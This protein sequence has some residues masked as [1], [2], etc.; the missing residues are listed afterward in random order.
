MTS[1][2]PALITDLEKLDGPCREM[3][4]AVGAYWPDPK[5]F[6]MSIKQQRGMQPP[7][8]PFTASIDAAVALAE[9]VLPGWS[10]GQ[11]KCDDGDWQ[12]WLWPTVETGADFWEPD[13]QLGHSCYRD[14]PSRVLGEHS[15][16]AIAIVIATLRASASKEDG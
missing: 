7:V 3:D 16:E 4:L 5:P 6:S 2:D 1:P 9:R 12:V 10:R 15:S 8:Y 11:E 13:W 14:H